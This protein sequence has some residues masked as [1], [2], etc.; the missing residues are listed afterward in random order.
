MGQ[1]GGRGS[2]SADVLR[3]KLPLLA[4]YVEARRDGWTSRVYAVSAQG[5]TTA[6]RTSESRASRSRM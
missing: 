4:Q 3:H 1:G 5:S 2:G 6:T